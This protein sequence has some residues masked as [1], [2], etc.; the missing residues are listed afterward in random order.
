MANRGGS[1]SGRDEARRRARQQPGHDAEAAAE[2]EDGSSAANATGIWPRQA[3]GQ[4]EP[5]YQDTAAGGQDDLEAQ[6]GDAAAGE[7]SDWESPQAWVASARR[8]LPQQWSPPGDATTGIRELPGRQ[9]YP[10]GD[11]DPDSGWQQNEPGWQFPKRS[12]DRQWPQ[13]ARQARGRHAAS[14]PPRR[15]EWDPR[16]FRLSAGL[17]IWMVLILAFMI[18]GTVAAIAL[19][20]SGKVII[21]N[22]DG[23]SPAIRISAGGGRSAFPGQSTATAGARGAA[24]AVPGLAG[25]TF[26][27]GIM[28]KFQAELPASGPRQSAVIGYENYVRSMWYAVATRG[29][30][31]AYKQYILGNARAFTQSLV[32]EFSTNGWKLRGTIVY[33]KISVPS[34]YASGSAVVSACVDASGL[35]RV[36]AQTGD[37]V[38]SVFGTTYDHYLEEASVGQ[39]PGSATRPGGPWVVTHTGN[40]PSSSGGAARACT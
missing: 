32:G 22:G 28:V 3:T 26:P 36:N 4:D 17:V 33:Y 7:S 14:S 21:S 25:F 34:V 40:I 10:A 11:Q 1:G 16:L 15:P 9:D 8:R 23:P 39:E 38:G 35:Y 31:T 20:M 30:G 27:P 29:S 13:P 24:S 2:D 6:D 18:A 19:L 5:G 12:A 37:V